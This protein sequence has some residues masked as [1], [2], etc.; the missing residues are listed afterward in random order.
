MIDYKNLYKFTNGLNVL[1]IEDDEALRVNSVELF[2]E[3]FKKVDNAIDGNAGLKEYIKF[4]KNNETYYDIVFTD[5]TMPNM[6]GHK[7]IDELRKINPSQVIIVISAYQETSRF[8]KLIEQGIESFILK[9]IKSDN[10]ISV[11][12]K[13]SKNINNGK[14]AKK[15]VK[16][17]KKFNKLLKQRVREEIKKNTQKEIRL[18]EQANA[19]SK[20]YEIQKHKDIFLANMSH[21][22]RTPLNGIIGFTN[23]IKNTKLT[24]EQRKYINLISTSSEILST[25]IND[26]LDFSKIAEGKLELDEQPTNCKIELS[27]LLSIFEPRIQEKN[28]KFIINIDSKLP[29]CI[30]YDQTRLKQ[31]IMNLIGNAIKFTH[32]GS[33]EFSATVLSKTNDNVTVKYSIKDTGIGIAKDKQKLIFQAFSQEDKSTSTKFGGTGLGISI[34]DGL[35]ELAGG[36]LK[37]NSTPNIGT[38]FYFILKS[39]TCKK[40]LIKKS[41]I[42]TNISKFYKAHILVAEDNLINQELMKTILTNKN[43]KITIANNGQEVVDIYKKDNTTFNMIF[44][45]INMPIISGLE[46]LNQIRNFE[47]IND[48]KNVPI[49]ALTANS[50][51]GNKE[52]YIQLGMDDYLSK[53]LNMKDLNNVLYNF[54]G[55]YIVEEILKPKDKIIK[56]NDDDILTYDIQ[57]IAT[58][59]EV[60]LQIIKKLLKIFFDKFNT[61][62][63]EIYKAVK[64]KDFDNLYS[65]LHT[66]KGTS[67]NLRLQYILELVTTMEQHAK[68]SNKNFQ[69]KEQ[70]KL[71]EKYIQDYKN[72]LK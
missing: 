17:V 68:S 38:E 32:K 60:D 29:N 46:A 16:S 40:N 2:E 10:L 55:E 31:I 7:L 66:I 48:I 20:E 63:K 39:K 70:L 12:Y 21:E 33:I 1:Y 44:M 43:I 57:N 4:H 64:Q 28:L 47:K 62:I 14:L 71:L 58:Q 26:I 45:D 24:K 27:K 6:D 65:I 37:L 50:I 18:L 72:I 8:I 53:P 5:I 61:Q 59:L 51:K 11:L 54:L 30:V 13:V 15:H 52:K 25:V 23:I 41:N 42:N 67:G 9:P 22:I 49:V 35:V 34:A 56:N 36:K 3:F 69:W 19:L